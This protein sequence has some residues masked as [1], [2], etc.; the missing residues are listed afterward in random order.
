MGKPGQR[1]LDILGLQHQSGR[2]GS[3]ASGGASKEAVADGTPPQRLLLVIDTFVNCRTR[4]S[5]TSVPY[6]LMIQCGSFRATP[7][8]R[9]PLAFAR[10][11]AYVAGYLQRPQKRQWEVCSWTRLAWNL[12]WRAALRSSR[13]RGGSLCTVAIVRSSSSTTAGA[14][15]PSTIGARTWASRSSAAASR[16]A[17]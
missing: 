2:Y 16:T 7:K 12:R 8:P 14:S 6:R 4:L 15:S 11:D 13:S 1:T 10:E 5:S 3:R 9:H 17:S